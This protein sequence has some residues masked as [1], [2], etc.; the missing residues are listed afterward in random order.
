MLTLLN[1]FVFFIAVGVIAYLTYTAVSKTSLNLQDK[2]DAIPIISQE[3]LTPALI[4]PQ[5]DCSPVGRDPFVVYEADSLNASSFIAA[6]RVAA[7]GDDEDSAGQLMGII[8]GDDGRRLALIDGQIYSVGALIKMPDSD[9][10]W[11]IYS[12]DDKSVVLTSNGKQT[13]L[14]ILDIY[15][16]YDDFGDVEEDIMEVEN[17][18]E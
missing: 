18:R 4:E 3:M 15:A 5:A 8:I 6:Q 1:K 12:I 11:Q 14:K 9:E 10:L 17:Y 16:D 7:G 13:V 2:E